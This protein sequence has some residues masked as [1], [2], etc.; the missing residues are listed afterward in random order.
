[1]LLLGSLLKSQN[2]RIL[3]FP[4]MV[5]LRRA[6]LVKDLTLYQFIFQA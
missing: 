2:E 4:I 1:M 5:T 3:F 6:F